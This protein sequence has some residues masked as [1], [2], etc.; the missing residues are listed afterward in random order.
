MSTIALHSTL[1]ISETGWDRGLVLK[2]HHRKWHMGYGMV[3]RPT[4][5]RDPQRCC[6]AVRSAILETA[7][8]LVT[9]LTVLHCQKCHNFASVWQKNSV[10]KW[11]KVAVTRAP[12]CFI[13][14]A[15]AATDY[16]I[17]LPVPV[18]WLSSVS[19]FITHVGKWSLKQQHAFELRLLY[20]SILLHQH[21]LIMPFSALCGGTAVAVPPPFRP[22]LNGGSTAATAALCG[23]HPLVTPY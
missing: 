20:S 8:L 5:S 12:L 15:S 18:N 3:M 21:T 22:C 2:D 13:A 6:E 19:D 16:W 11:L 4:M 9:K 14:N 17:W 1:N 10:S 23:S 7:W